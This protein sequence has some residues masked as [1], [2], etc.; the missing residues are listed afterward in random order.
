MPPH[1]RGRPHLVVCGD[2]RGRVRAGH[3]RLAHA[4]RRLGEGALGA[5]E[6]QR[7]EAR[8]RDRRRHEGRVARLL[9]L[10]GLRARRDRARGGRPALPRLRHHHVRAGR[11]LARPVRRHAPQGRP[12]RRRSRQGHRRKDRGLASGPSR[13]LRGRIHRRVRRQGGRQR[14]GRHLPANGADRPRRHGRPP[15]AQAPARPPTRSPTRRSPGSTAPGNT[16][17]ATTTTSSRP[18]CGPSAAAAPAVMDPPSPTV[19]TRTT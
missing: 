13:R 6:G 16:R 18:S 14:Q 5:V 9:V 19:W 12:E 7:L 17:R 8:G 15:R 2:G 10:D 1:P 4:L 11:L 3:R